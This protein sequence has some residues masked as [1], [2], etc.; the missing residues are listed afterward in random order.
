M[1]SPF[2]MFIS[3]EEFWSP[4]QHQ[5][6]H[7]TW[8]GEEKTHIQR[9]YFVSTYTDCNLILGYG[10]LFLYVTCH[11]IEPTVCFVVAIT[12]T[13]VVCVALYV[14]YTRITWTK[15]GLSAF[16]Q[17]S[18]QPNVTSWRKIINSWVPSPGHRILAPSVW[19][20]TRTAIPRPQI[21]YC[22]L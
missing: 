20:P 12:I 9:C 13:T 10:I 21:F 19:F 3:Y 2:V 14:D 18:S 15:C 22:L 4:S 6:T 8:K 16:I 1:G 5:V 7:L 17:A 11:K